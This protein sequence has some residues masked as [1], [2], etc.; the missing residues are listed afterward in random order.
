MSLFE[1]IMLRAAAA[2]R[3]R[4]EVRAGE[5]ADVLGTEPGIEAT[6]N[7]E[8]VVL[9]GRGLRWRMATDPALRRVSGRLR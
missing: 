9:R 7:E 8:G 5:V 6:A 3:K 1:T 2:A 4:A